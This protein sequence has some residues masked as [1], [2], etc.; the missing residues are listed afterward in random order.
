MGDHNQLPPVVKNMAFSKFSNL[1]QSLFT[2]LIS[3]G[4]P[5]VQLDKQGRARAEI[6]SLYSWRYNS[7]GNL[8]H[9]QQSEEFQLA[10]SGF[11]NTFQLINV[12]AFEGRG[13][14]S[15]TAYFYQNV[16]EAEFA[17]ALFQYMVLIGHA[18]ERI[19][20][21]TTYNGQKA[22]IQDIL[23]QRCGEGTPLAGIRPASTESRSIGI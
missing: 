5:Y 7:L 20:I 21:L 4:V 15:P 11:A 1:N 19:T 3:L 6:A 17:V 23:A 13:E 14:S 2:R 22:L 16:G 8:D 18:P 9:V 12:E 10:N